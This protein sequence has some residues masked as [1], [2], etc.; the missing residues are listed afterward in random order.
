MFVCVVSDM[1]FVFN[2]LSCACLLCVCNL[3]CVWK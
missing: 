3:L 2:V 1:C